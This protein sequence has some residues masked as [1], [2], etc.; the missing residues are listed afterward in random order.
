[1]PKRLVVLISGSGSNLQMLIDA[2][3]SGALDAQ[4]VCVV[5]NRMAAYGLER[6]R[7]AGL[8]TLYRP[9]KPYT[10][11]G[12]PRAVYDADLAEDLK[13]YTPDLIVCAGWMHIF[14]LAFLAHFT[15]GV[16]NLHPALPGVL[17]GKDSLHETF[18]TAQRGGENA[19]ETGCMVHL[20]VPE[21]DAGRV[22]DLERV[23]V[24]PGE[25]L[26]AFAERMHAAEHLLIVRAVR[27]FLSQEG[28]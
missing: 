28:V 15:D 12:W 5:S 16:I 10:E 20:V 14:S 26:E 3:A 17:A 21:V 24:V 23:P 9:L 2:C 13:A 8:E 22:I 4:I 11:G 27:K 18:E 7:A 19:V 1:M 6:A 25:A